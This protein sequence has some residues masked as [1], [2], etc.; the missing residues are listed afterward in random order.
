MNS[1]VSCL[2]KFSKRF[3]NLIDCD[4]TALSKNKKR[5]YLQDMSEEGALAVVVGFQKN[6]SQLTL[7]DRVV[8]RVEL[9]E[10]VE[11]IPVLNETSK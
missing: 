5:H 4:A 10:P 9:I 8:L 3:S 1:Q 6:V 11:G 7:P 2:L